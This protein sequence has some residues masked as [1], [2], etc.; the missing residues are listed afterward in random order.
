MG[1]QSQKPPKLVHFGYKFAQKGYIPLSDFYKIWLGEGVLGPHRLAVVA[2]K[3][4]PKSQRNGNFWYKF[5]LKGK[6]WGFTEKVEYKCTTAYL[7]LCNNTISVLKITWLYHKR[8]H[9]TA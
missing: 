1:L 6:F 4:A 7:Y 9:S 3:N 5:A 2:L 8:R